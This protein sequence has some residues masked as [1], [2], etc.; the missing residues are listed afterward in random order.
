MKDLSEEKIEN[1]RNMQFVKEYLGKTNLAAQIISHPRLESILWKLS[2]LMR[3]AGVRAFSQE[4]IQLLN[5]I[6]I[7]QANGNIT[8][9]ENKG[10]A[11]DLASTQYY[12][13]SEANKLRRV[14]CQT[15]AD[16][17]EITQVSTYNEEGLEEDLLI[18]QKCLDGSKHYSH[19]TR[20]PERIDLVE[21]ESIAEK[22]G[23][24]TRLGKAYQLRTF[25]PAYEDIDPSA[26]EIDPFDTI[27]MSFLGV[28]P[29][30]RDLE[31][32]ELKIIEECDGEIFP[33]DDVHKEEQFQDYVQ[34]NQFYGRTRRFEEAVA[35]YLAIEE[36][37]QS[38]KELE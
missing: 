38:E 26:D 34:T 36:R 16:S 32:E 9:F 27:G 35:S 24:R 30:Y 7:I 12:F 37:L 18:E 15:N 17:T 33:L 19:T 5:S 2:I 20:V 8:I 3:K 31:P 4:A 11:M 6:V 28:P 1:T 23:I 10:N 13:D 29:I 25:C 22:N 21:V 14:F